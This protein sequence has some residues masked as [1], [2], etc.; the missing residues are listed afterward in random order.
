MVRQCPDGLTYCKQSFKVY[1]LLT[2][3][4]VAGGITKKEIESGN[5]TLIESVNTSYLWT[6]GNPPTV[7][8]VNL[9]FVANGRSAYFAFQDT[10]ACLSL[11]SVVISYTYCPSVVNH[12]VVFKMVAAPSSN[13]HNLTVNG[14]CSDKASPDPSNNT[15]AL[16]CLSSG[17]W[18]TDDTVT[19]Q[20]TA[21]YELLGDTCTGEINICDFYLCSFIM[22]VCFTMVTKNRPFQSLII[23]SCFVQ[24]DQY[25]NS[26]L[27]SF[28][29]YD[30]QHEF[31]LMTS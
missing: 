11:T 23:Y 26:Y 21:G 17:Q 4:P 5:F 31:S 12:G 18:V 20:C 7:N 27:I 9:T 1:G 22:V 16:T 8:Q 15:L 3:G 6:P 25:Q 19:C 2:Q 29:G 10:G 14:S 13:Q 24:Y 28:A 30:H